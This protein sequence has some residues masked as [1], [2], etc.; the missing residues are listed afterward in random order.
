MSSMGAVAGWGPAMRRSDSAVR[1]TRRGRL[2]RSAA[3]M[4][5]AVVALVSAIGRVDAGV[6]R[7]G[8]PAATSAPVATASVV[9]EQGDSLWEI[10]ASLAPDRDPRD[11]IHEIR[12]LN[13]LRG[14]LIQP[15]QVLLVP[16]S[17]AHG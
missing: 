10:A 13:G 16:S 3:A 17:V 7:A 14:S 11:V 1:L 5:I 8:A 9:V 12:D 4:A 6:A 15:G 2:V